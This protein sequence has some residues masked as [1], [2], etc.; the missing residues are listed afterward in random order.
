MGEPLKEEVRDPY[1][2]QWWNGFMQAGEPCICTSFDIY[3]TKEEAYW[4]M[5]EHEEPN[6]DL[7]HWLMPYHTVLADKMRIQEGKGGLHVKAIQAQMDI[8]WEEMFKNGRGWP[9]RYSQ[10]VSKQRNLRRSYG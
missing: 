8:C 10:P 4:A 1:V 7:R 6:P 3:H 5:F 9:E 2:F